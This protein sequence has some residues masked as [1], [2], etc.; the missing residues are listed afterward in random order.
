M[1]LASRFYYKNFRAFEL[2]IDPKFARFTVRFSNQDITA[3]CHFIKTEILAAT[4]TYYNLSRRK[5]PVIQS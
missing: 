2:W 3:I 4:Q 5:E 1:S